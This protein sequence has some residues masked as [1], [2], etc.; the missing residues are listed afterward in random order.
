MA[1]TA[2]MVSD[3][4]A[5]IHTLLLALLYLALTPGRLF[6]HLIPTLAQVGRCARSTPTRLLKRPWR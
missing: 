1:T 6:A 2:T 5:L 4:G 3:V